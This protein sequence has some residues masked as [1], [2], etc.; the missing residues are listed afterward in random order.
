[1][2]P[3]DTL[4]CGRRA[5][6]RRSP[7]AEDLTLQFA[8]WSHPS[9]RRGPG[10]SPVSLP[11]DRVGRIPGRIID[12]EGGLGPEGSQGRLETSSRGWV[13]IMLLARGDSSPDDDARSCRGS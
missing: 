3:P 1:M 4:A 7:A 13:W 11:S 10:R 9:G 12:P 6:S 2:A 8:G 5:G